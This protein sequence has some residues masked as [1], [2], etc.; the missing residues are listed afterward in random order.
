MVVISGMWVKCI[1]EMR[2]VGIMWLKWNVGIMW[3]LYEECGYNMVVIGRMW[4]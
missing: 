3:W 1:S 2:N 4:V